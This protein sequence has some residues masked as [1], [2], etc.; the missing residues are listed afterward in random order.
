[1]DKLAQITAETERFLRMI[2]EDV[3]RQITGS[4]IA[5]DFDNNSVDFTA[6]YVGSIS[7]EQVQACNH[8]LAQTIREDTDFD[9]F[10]TQIRRAT[11][12]QYAKIAKPIAPDDAIYF[13]LFDTETES[14]K[15]TEQHTLTKERSLQIEQTL[16][17]TDRIQYEGSTQG[18]IMALFKD[19]VPHFRLRE[20]Y[21]EEWFPCYFSYTLYD[22]VIYALQNKDTVVHVAGLITASRTERRPLD[23]QV[24]RIENAVEYIEGDLEKFI[25]CAPYATGDLSTEQFI[26]LIRGRDE[27]VG[28]RDEA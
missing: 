19:N 9:H 14:D 15:P 13:G 16:K 26:D 20:L 28:D 2:V 10:G 6:S 4:W 3:N 5:K 21:S 7:P 11:L 12:L 17:V 24:K 22:K 27:L 23:M 8:A 25:G 18:T 1:M